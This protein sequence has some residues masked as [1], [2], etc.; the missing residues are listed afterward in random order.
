MIDATYFG[1]LR[2]IYTRLN[3]SNVNWV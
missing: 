2:K 1:V 3:N